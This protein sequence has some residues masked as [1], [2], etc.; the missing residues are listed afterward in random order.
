MVVSPLF[1]L[2]GNKPLKKT[3]LNPFFNKNSIDSE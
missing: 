2:A 1:T 3:L